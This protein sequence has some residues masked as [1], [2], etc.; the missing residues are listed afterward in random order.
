MIYPGVYRGKIF[1]VD[2]SRHRAKVRVPQIDGREVGVS[3]IDSDNLHDSTSLISLSSSDVG[4]FVIVSYIGGD[5]NF[6]VIL[7][8]EW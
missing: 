5:P 2:E 8:K 4:K 3:S 7:G 1:S 6:P